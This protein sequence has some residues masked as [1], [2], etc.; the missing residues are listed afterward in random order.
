MLARPQATT[1]PDGH[2]LDRMAAPAND[3]AAW[4]EGKEWE[5]GSSPMA[6]TASEVSHGRSRRD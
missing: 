5:M 1:R 3:V 2:A 4:P 6:A